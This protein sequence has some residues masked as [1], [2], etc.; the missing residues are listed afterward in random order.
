VLTSAW[1]SLMRVLSRY[2]LLVPLIIIAIVVRDWVEDPATIA[3]E[4]TIEMKDTRSDYYLEEFVTRRFTSNGY[5]EYELH[6]QSL[7][8]YPEDDHSQIIKPVM[9]MHRPAASWHL[10]SG[11]GRFDTNPDVL[12]LQG[13]VTVQRL[14]NT[15]ESITI[16]TS[17]IQV[18]TDKNLVR[19]DKPITIKGQ[20][21]RLDAVGLQSAIDDGKLVLI[22]Q[23]TGR[24][25]P[26]TEP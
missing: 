5:L 14:S 8:H 10:V 23:V 9:T 22:S 2:W 13:D 11:E 7:A 24:Y 19:T 21:W 26:P 1:S 6:G 3:D 12:T 15:D 16:T 18:E 20:N 4:A 25:D 17:D